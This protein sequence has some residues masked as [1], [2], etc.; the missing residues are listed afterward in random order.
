MVE[1]AAHYAPKD[2]TIELRAARVNGRL[3]VTVDDRGPGIPEADL[4]RVF[5]RFYLVERARTR[6]HG[7]TGLGL[8]IVRHLTGLQQGTVAAANRPG[9]GTVFTV[10]LP[11]EPEGGAGS[12]G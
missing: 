8:A 3:V 11:P 7:G 10:S 4:S 9:G 5:E 12:S 6:N 1:N 2:S